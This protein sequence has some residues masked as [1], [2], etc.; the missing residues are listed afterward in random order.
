MIA[1]GWFPSAGDMH[2][3]IWLG[4]VAFDYTATAVAVAHLIH[5]CMRKHWCT[6]ELIHEAIGDCCLL[7]RL[8][9]ERL[10]LGP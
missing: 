8:P 1:E 4:G 5:D 9:C 7:P 10:F 6:V 2:L 3:R